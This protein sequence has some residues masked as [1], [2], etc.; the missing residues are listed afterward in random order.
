MHLTFLAK[1]L[2]SC[3]N[4]ECILVWGLEGHMRAAGTRD[5]QWMVPGILETAYGYA[6]VQA[7]SAH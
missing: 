2:Q 5:L 6:Q 7:K 4:A 1:Q 3:V